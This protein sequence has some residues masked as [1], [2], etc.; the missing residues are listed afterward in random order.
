VVE[1]LSLLFVAAGLVMLVSA[2][3]VAN[4]LLAESSARHREIGIRVALGAGRLRVIRQLLT[5]SLLVCLAGASLGL[6][7]ALMLMSLIPAFGLPFKIPL[8]FHLSLDARVLGFSALLSLL[9]AMISGLA[10]ALIASG[11]SPHESLKETSTQMTVARTGRHLQNSLVVAQVAIAFVSVAGAALSLRGLRNAKATNLGFDPHGVLEATT[12]SPS[13]RYS[14]QKGLRFYSQLLERLERAPGI[15]SEALAEFAPLSLLRRTARVTREGEEN[16]S[17]NSGIQ[18]EWEVLSPGYFRTLRVPILRGRD[19]QSEDDRNAPPVVIV[20]R[21]LAGALWPHEEVVGKRIRLS[22]ER[23]DREVIGM[24]ADM[25]YHELWEA[26]LPYVYLPLAQ[27]YAPE[28]Q[29][30]VRTEGGPMSV[31]PE[32]RTA[33]AQVDPQVPVFDVETLEEQ[34]ARS[35]SQPKML[36]SL[37]GSFGV[38]TLILSVIGTYGLLSFDAKRRTHEVGIRMALGAQR[39]NVLGLVISK[40]F[41]LTLLGVGVGIVGALGLARLFSSILYD[42]RPAAPP[43]FVAVS[44]ILLAVG[45]V[46]SYIP[47]RRATKVD[48]MVALRHE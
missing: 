34:V 11:S 9:T 8:A 30:F 21:T 37:L 12:G 10:P 44:L 22:G 6:L 43:T 42:V 14:E 2:A 40:G 3:D 4:L 33:V 39:G 7:V 20:N 19:F 16:T 28:L 31:L 46:A 24:A 1:V 18:A 36:S 23:A 41:K 13:Q 26:P 29:L 27:S 35:L 32:V 15:Q 45:L 25:K 47:A 38:L 17:E 5:E 48:P